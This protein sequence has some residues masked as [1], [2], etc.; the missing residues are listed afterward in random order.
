MQGT[1]SFHLK[2][3][4]KRIVIDYTRQIRCCKNDSPGSEKIDQFIAKI[5]ENGADLSFDR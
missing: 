3:W 1:F 4:L 2:T 5:V